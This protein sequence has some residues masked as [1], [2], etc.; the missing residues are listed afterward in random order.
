[1]KL[2]EEAT[3]QGDCRASEKKVALLWV[4]FEYFDFAYQISFNHPPFM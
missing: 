2:K 3:A 4:F 1:M